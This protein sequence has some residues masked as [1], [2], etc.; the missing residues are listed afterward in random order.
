MVYSDGALVVVDKPAGLLSVP[1][2]GEHKQ[3]CAVARVRAMFPE[4]SG[5]MV[6]HRLDMDTSGLLIVALTEEAQR[7]LSRQFESRRVGKTYVALLEGEVGG[8]EGLIDLPIRPDVTNRPYQIVDFVHGRPSQTRWRVLARE[9]DRTR[10]HFEPLTGRAHQLRVHAAAP[11][12]VEGR[13]GGL[14]SPIVGDVLYSPNPG[15]E[16][17]MLHASTL[18]F[19]HPETGRWLEFRLPCPF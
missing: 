8:E 5:P 2:K 7:R 3:D 6:V 4:A 15:G 10:V 13:P 16:R 19:E 18:S 17:L 14:G 11:V 1:G 12:L 9:I